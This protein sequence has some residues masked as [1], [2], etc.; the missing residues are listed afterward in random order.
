MAEAVESY[1]VEGYTV[2]REALS[3][4]E[5]SAICGEARQVLETNHALLGLPAGPG[6]ELEC[7]VLCLHQ[8]HKLSPVIAA[9]TKDTRL[10]EPL[11]PI[12]GDHIKLVQTQ[13]FFKAPGMPGNGWHQDEA[14]IPSRDRSLVGAWLALDS[15]TKENGCMQVVPAS[16]LNGYIYPEREHGTPERWD[17]STVSYEFDETSAISV[18]MSPGDLL[19]FSGYLLHGSEP[20]RSSNMRR[21]VTFHYMNAYSLLPWK[22]AATERGEVI[23]PASLD[24]R[25]VVIVAGE[26]PY[27]WK[28]YLDES[29]PHLRK[30]GS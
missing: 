17:F 7:K 9:L 30:W 2:I 27:S 6:N 8:I 3:P 19:L 18:E 24:Y 26:D 22:V 4:R 25:D 29:R 20:N 21:A 5:A 1:F 12:I 14:A 23:R 16:H 11:L 13:F 10:V 28:G 15:A